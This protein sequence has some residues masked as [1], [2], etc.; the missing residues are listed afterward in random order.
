MLMEEY[1]GYEKRKAL[2]LLKESRA[3][4]ELRTTRS[5]YFKVQGDNADYTV[6]YDRRRKRW[7]CDCLHWVIRSKKCS[8]ILASE[9]LLSKLAE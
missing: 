5:V 7:S 6:K 8:H 1:T 9:I 2:R 4:I 3:R